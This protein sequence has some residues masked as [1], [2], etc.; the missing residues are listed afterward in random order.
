MARRELLLGLA[1]V[2]GSI[3]LA[4]CGVD[5]SGQEA[6]LPIVESVELQPLVAQVRRVVAALETIGEPILS[7]EERAA[8]DAAAASTDER[9]A[10][11]S[12]QEVLDRHC[13]FGVT[14][15]PESRVK[16]ERGP[17]KAELVEQGWRSFLVKVKNEAGITAR[18]RFLSKNAA[19]LF[20][21]VDGPDPPVEIGAAELRERWLDGSMFEQPPLLP[22]LSGLALEYR[23]L[24]LYSRDAGQREAS[25]SFDVGSG[26]ADLGFRNS[27]ALLFEAR[28][29]V[30]LV[31]H[32]RD[33]NGRPTT[34]AFVIRDRQGRVHP[35]PSKRLAPDF[36]FHEQVYRAD[37]E[38]V[39][40]PA[41]EYHIDC[42]R[43]P[44]YV[45]TRQTVLVPTPS[46]D[47]A[48]KPPAATFELKR[49]IDPAARGWFS[50]DH[51]VHAAGCAHYT[52]PSRGVGPNDMLRHIIGEDLDVGCVLSWGPCWYHQKT[53]F[54]GRVSE[55]STSKNL[56]RY[57]VEVS[58]F[59]SSHAGHLC[60]LGLTED[61]YPGTTRIE[62]WPSFDLPILQ[63][64]KGQGALAGFSHSGFGLETKD[65][66]LPSFEVP[67]YDGIGANE[68]V[69]DVT[70]DAVDFISAGDTPWPF[71]LSIWYHTN[72]A[73]FRT[74]ISGETDFPCI[75]GERV[76]LGRVYAK[77][78]GAL[79]YGKWLAAVKAG[80][81]YVSEGHAHLFD[82][83]AANPDASGSATAT[84]WCSVGEGTSELHLA[85]PATIRVRVTAAALLG[86]QE[87]PPGRDR[88]VRDLPLDQWPYW[89]VE[90][91]RVA[92][93]RTVPVEIVVN[94][95]AR[96][97][98]AILADGSPN[99]LAF[100]VPIERSSWIA[101]RIVACAHTNPIYVLVEDRPIRASRRSV[102]WCL[103]GVE[104]CWRSK[105]PNLKPEE[106]EACA[107]AYDRAR[108]V[109]RARLA[110]CETD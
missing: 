30:D 69:V 53:F 18:L 81:S 39:R 19:S 13:L 4:G 88:P 70:H 78:D 49:W 80:R 5:A 73:G 58:G 48:V 75:S 101:C 108:E 28:P 47:G 92:G 106:R 66:L 62:E 36:F 77:V 55:L 95:I 29:S 94:G 83:A 27:V 20:R 32:V 42:T 110:E 104:Q 98:R 21:Q 31:L 67:R 17:A 89:N 68:Y 38:T 74:K 41:G 56:M 57:D 2:I 23:I 60:L 22:A 7:T 8:I 43:G 34:A 76:G 107:R 100:D 93:T 99:E 71:E 97:E 3:V 109:Y 105:S 51:H 6:S 72:D 14:I 90:R 64:T 1:G 103:D 96:A 86:E 59:P 25:V 50:G 44:H 11:R 61:D 87:V 12:I 9:S 46:P 35:P 24:Q 40:L 37:G 26:T 91:A 84:T 10:A 79:E 54:E 85:K 82:F 15:N 65:K 33:E 63:W 52:D 45:T 102:Q 16:V